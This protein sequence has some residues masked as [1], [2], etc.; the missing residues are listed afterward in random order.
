MWDGKL[1]T[2][3]HYVATREFPYVMGCFKGTPIQNQFSG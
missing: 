2:M 3:Y 1:V